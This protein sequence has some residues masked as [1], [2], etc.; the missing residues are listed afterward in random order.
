MYSQSN[1]NT[2]NKTGIQWENNKNIDIGS[3]MC[4][5][6]ALTHENFFHTSLSKVSINWEKNSPGKAKH[7]LSASH[8]LKAC[9]INQPI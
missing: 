8:F 6:H 7:F 1:F 3:K 4:C 5:I 9:S 2:A